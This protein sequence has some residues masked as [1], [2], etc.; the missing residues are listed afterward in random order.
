MSRVKQTLSEPLNSSDVFSDSFGGAI[1]V[2]NYPADGV[3][4]EQLLVVADSNMYANKAETK[5]II[6]HL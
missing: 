3:T 5:K 6:N 4:I 2:A 1:G